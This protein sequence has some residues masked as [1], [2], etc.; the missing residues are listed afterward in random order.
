MRAMVLHEFG[1]PLCMEEVPMPEPGMGQVL[2]RV[3]TCGLCGSDIKITEG[4]INTTPLPFIPG[5]EIAGEIVKCGAGVSEDML[6]KRVV[7][8][9]YVSCMTCEACKAGFY[10]LCENLTGRLG[11][12]LSGGLGEYVVIPEQ[13]AVVIPDGVSYQEACIAPCAMLA[14]YHGINRADIKKQDRVLILGAGGLGIHGI[15]FLA[16]EN[17]HVT[18]VDLTQEKVDLARSFG[19]SEAILFK[20]FMDMK[21]KYSAILDNVVK[22]DITKACAKRLGKNG[23][24]VMVGYS[25]GVDSIFDSEYM[26]LNETVFIGTRNGT[27]QELREIL[28]MEKRGEIKAVIDCVLPLSEAGKALEMIKAGRITGRV[29]ISHEK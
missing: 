6:G 24:Y 2:L 12:E 15:Q 9:L 27:I 18:A 26:H 1:K 25:P 3:H 11:F 29:V 22:P 4:K 23:R 14:I 17:I 21:D 19:A 5:H 20:S 28:N 10:N 16:A 8:H 7:S 13:N